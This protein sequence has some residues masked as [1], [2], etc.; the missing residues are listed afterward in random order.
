MNIGVEVSVIIPVFNAEKTLN[1][2]VESLLKQ[3]FRDFELLLIND[4]S[5]DR[6]G[7]ICNKYAQKDQRIKVFHKENGGVSSAR[8][9]GLKV[10]KGEYIVFCDADDWVSEQYLSNLWNDKQYDLS[11]SSYYEVSDSMQGYRFNDII[12]ETKD[13]I[14]TLYRDHISQILLRTP[15]GKLWKRKIIMDHAIFF[16]PLIKSGQDTVWCFQYYQ[17]VRSI[18]MVSANDYFYQQQGNAHLSQSV[19]NVDIAHY[20]AE[21]I[22]EALAGMEKI[23]DIDLSAIKLKLTLWFFYRFLSSTF[24]DSV[25][26]IRR[27]FI[28]IYNK[29]YFHDMFIHQG[30]NIKGKRIKILDWLLLNK[31]F[32]LLAIYIKLSRSPY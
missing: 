23:F 16:D 15:W 18:K 12:C 28:S 14:G 4:G 9:I 19:L 27:Q 29:R 30:A 31:Y 3:T 11:V 22:K 10:A 1:K 25:W 26:S 8:N 20:T 13:K 6:S 32:F 5:Q 17:H 24:S 7:D 2:C 21:R